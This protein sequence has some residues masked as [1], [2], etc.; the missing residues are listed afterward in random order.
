MAIYTIQLFA[1]EAAPIAFR[2]L[3]FAGDA[4]AIDHARTMLAGLE[5][6]SERT[7]SLRVGRG[8]GDHIVWLG[9]WSAAGGAAAWRPG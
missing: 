2:E 5:G 6:F 9:R 7:L 1:R 8:R 4:E 3:D